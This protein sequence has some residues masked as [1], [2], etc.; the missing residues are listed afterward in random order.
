MKQCN[1]YFEQISSFV[2]G[3]LPDTEQINLFIHLESCP[4]CPKVLEMYQNMSGAFAHVDVDPPVGFSDRVMDRIAEKSQ[5]PTVKVRHRTAMRRFVA[6]AAVFAVVA[7]I[8]FGSMWGQFGNDSLE[9]ADMLMDMSPEATAD[10]DTPVAESATE[11]MPD[12][13][14]MVPAEEAEN[15][16][17]FE[18]P[19]P[20]DELDQPLQSLVVAPDTR[21]LETVFTGA[22]WQW[23]ALSALFAEGGYPVQ[24]FDGSMF[25][26][27]DPYNPGSLLYGQLTDDPAHA[28][29]V[30][31]SIL[32]YQF[33]SEDVNRRVEARLLDGMVYYY[34]NITAA[35]EGGNRAA[36]WESL[37]NFIVQ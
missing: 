6:V 30:V 12:A 11:V 32:G 28:D 27:R 22:P 2:D 35:W 13:L 24:L 34:Y 37:R 36:D 20:Y 29:D 33:I 18:D 17:G 1:E 21:L 3:A 15:F 31:V 14:R 5:T 25:E 9:A 23:A 7:V 4:S 16:M 10:A 26:V 19:V 8:G